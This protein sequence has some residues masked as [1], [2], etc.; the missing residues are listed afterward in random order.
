MH[1]NH[2]APSAGTSD[3]ASAPAG[4]SPWWRNAVFYQVY[5]RSFADSDG[6]GNGDLAGIT[7]RLPYLR[8]LGV[9]GLWLTPFYRSPL[10]DGGYDV[11]DP[12]DVDPT[13]GDL[14]AFDVL[15]G[16]A[17]RLGLRVTVD[18]VPNH[19]SDQHPWFGEALAAEVGSDERDRYIF[20]APAEE[21]GD[22]DLPNNWPS[23]FGGP[24]WTRTPDGQY[25]LHL[26]DPAQPD[27]NWDNQ[28]VADDLQETLRFWLDRGVDGFRIDVAHG[29]AK[30]AGL[31][32]LPTVDPDGAVPDGAPD[33]RF[34]NDGVH[35]IHRMIRG[36]LDEYPDRMSVGEVWA[37]DP[38]R[39][40][41]Y[42][43]PD[44]LRMV[45]NFSLLEAD[46]QPSHLRDAVDRSLAAVAPQGAP[47]CWVLSNHD[48]SRHRTRY[49]GG[50]VGER[51]ARAA[52]LLQL[53]LPGA[54]FVYQ[55]DE[56]GLEDVE[57]PDWALQDPTWERTGH[58]RRGRDGVR[59]PMPWQGDHPPYG[60]SDAEKTWLPMPEDWAARTTHAQWED[61][62]SHLQ[63][64]RAALQLRRAHHFFGDSSLTW[65]A[66]PQT[67]LALRR[68]H[69]LYVVL[70]LGDAPVRLPPGEVILTSA[71]L[72]D[73]LLPTD[74][75]AWVQGPHI[76]GWADDEG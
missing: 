8:D 15:I 25:Y 24:A 47:A 70:N 65:L 44:E 41:R 3:G 10:V 46:W 7:S 49:G 18:V 35:P 56:L 39:L 23:V 62:G 57:L 60:F 74:T 58:T 2:Q 30:P 53:G 52:A 67:V 43:R 45:F 63:L 40:T 36:T 28:Q 6:D 73:G 42:I 21:A 69:G 22:A 72:A 48:V 26:F 13:F 61:P 66:G 51:R 4:R 37:R 9:D 76:E 31:P 5:V 64:Y 27:L 16:E 29:M 11:A 38:E 50:V 75:S 33:L 19:S 54:A 55:G 12:R 1:P 59:V 34:D 20:R 68:S 14:D 71:A 17:H 32:D